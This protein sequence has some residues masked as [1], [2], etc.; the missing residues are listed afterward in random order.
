MTHVANFAFFEFGKLYDL[1][2]IERCLYAVR[3]TDAISMLMI[4][5]RLHDHAHGTTGMQ[6]PPSRPSHFRQGHDL[7]AG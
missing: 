7:R 2:V 4:G 3:E 6:R 1:I 5:R